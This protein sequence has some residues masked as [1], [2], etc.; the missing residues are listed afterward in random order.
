MAVHR[1]L[2]RTTAA[3][4]A[5]VGVSTL[6]LASAAPARATTAASSSAP[7]HLDW[8]TWTA[9]DGAPRYQI[10]GIGFT[11][12]RV[13]VV[14]TNKTGRTLWTR[15]VA[16]G[17]D[18]GLPEPTFHVGT[19]VRCDHRVRYVKAQDLGTRAWTQRYTL[20]PCIL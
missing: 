13:R 20:S 8:R 14:V 3:L 12:G 16:T 4:V 2:T 18:P 5:V 9:E 19:A 17:R 15:T 6:G 11:A 1:S 7:A 10:D